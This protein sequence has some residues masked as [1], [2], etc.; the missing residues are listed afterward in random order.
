[1]SN[2]THVGCYM[3]TKEGE[4]VKHKKENALYLVCAMIITVIKLFV[5][6]R[7]LSDFKMVPLG[8]RIK[9]SLSKFEYLW[10][11]FRIDK[12]VE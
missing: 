1:M 10:V 3:K 6:H 12:K 9:G 2:S 8:W 4:S 7:R 11:L 5:G